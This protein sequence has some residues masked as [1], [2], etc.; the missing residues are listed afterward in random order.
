[1]MY[2]HPRENDAVSTLKIA[3]LMYKLL[4]CL[5]NVTTNDLFKAIS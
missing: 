1:M 3:Y 5:L 2:V 4:K